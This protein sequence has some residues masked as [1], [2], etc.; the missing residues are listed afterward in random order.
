MALKLLD[1]LDQSILSQCFSTQ[2][3][4]VVFILFCICIYGYLVEK[5]KEINVKLI[6]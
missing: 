3:K 4:K 5:E 1:K 2:G 6:K